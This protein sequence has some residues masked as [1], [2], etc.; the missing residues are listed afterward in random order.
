M[1]F[2]F[3]VEHVFLNQLT[4]RDEIKFI[5]VFRTQREAYN[6]VRRLRR[7]PGFDETPYDFYINRY[8]LNRSVWDTGFVH[9]HRGRRIAVPHANKRRRLPLPGAIRLW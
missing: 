3:V 4:G 2:V 5:G 8:P 6:A 7:K 9:T 1:K